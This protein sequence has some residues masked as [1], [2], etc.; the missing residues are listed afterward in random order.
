VETC[1][2]ALDEMPGT[3]KRGPVE[4]LIADL[5]QRL[6]QAMLAQETIV[7]CGMPLWE[8]ADFIEIP[9]R[10]ITNGRRAI[11]LEDCARF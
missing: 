1:G 9:V 5:G 2:S 10:S 4:Q 7:V 8:C 6:Q 11:I 3:V